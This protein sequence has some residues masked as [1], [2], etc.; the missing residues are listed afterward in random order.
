[1]AAHALVRLEPARP[2]A[3]AEPDV[4]HVHISRVEV[5]GGIPSSEP[6][7][8]AAVTTAGVPGPLDLERYLAGERR[9]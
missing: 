3:K 1:M 4:V 6:A 2:A 8:R 7:H 9:R 5:R